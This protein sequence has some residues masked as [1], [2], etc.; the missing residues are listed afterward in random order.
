MFCIDFDLNV[1][2]IS[3]ILHRLQLNPGNDHF[4]TFSKN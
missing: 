1:V 2:F 3:E 4:C